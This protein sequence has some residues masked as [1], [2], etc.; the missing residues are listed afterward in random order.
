MY[1]GDFAEDATVHVPPFTTN[2]REGA[3]V[4]PSSAFEAADLLIYKDNGATQKA[5]TNVVTMTSPFDSI[6]G[7]HVVDIDTSNDTGDTG[8]WTTGS[9]YSVVLSPDETVDGKTV[10]ATIATFSIQNRYMRGTD[11]AALASV[12]TMAAINA[13]VVDALNTDTYAEPAQGAPAA[14]ASLVSKLG[15]LYKAW[16]NKST[17]T[18]TQYTLYADDTTTTDQKS[19]DADDGTTFTKGEV[20]T[21]A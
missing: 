4:A 17:Q 19:T 12:V 6:T 13:E 14:T 20:G 8:F 9:D 10:V 2:D 11:S 21:G 1:L 18:A 5:T 15:Y 3:A 16:R 7:L